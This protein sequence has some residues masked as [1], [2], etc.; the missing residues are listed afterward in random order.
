MALFKKF[1]L[2]GNFILTDGNQILFD[3]DGYYETEDEAEIAQLKPVY[4][5]VKE[6]EVKAAAKVAPKAPASAL[7]GIKTS[8]TVEAAAPTS[9]K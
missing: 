6:R 4:S 2:Q 9:G 8:G 3:A 1:Q 5:Q 7:A